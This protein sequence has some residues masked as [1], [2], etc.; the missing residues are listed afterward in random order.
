MF[1]KG[2]QAFLLMC[3]EWQPLR[4]AIRECDR[5]EIPGHIKILKFCVQTCGDKNEHR[6]LRTRLR[7][8]RYCPAG[9]ACR[10]AGRLLI[11]LTG[12][13]C[14]ARDSALRAYQFQSQ[15]RNEFESAFI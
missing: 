10:F 13:A 11:R 3:K 4:A 2:M 7:G 6:V 9:G 5:G 1:S 15:I 14:A 8:G 12:A